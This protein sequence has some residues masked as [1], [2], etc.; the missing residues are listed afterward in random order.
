MGV[1]TANF[2]TFS[3]PS[4]LPWK[5]ESYHVSATADYRRLRKCN[6]KLIIRLC[7][8]PTHCCAWFNL[9]E[10]GFNPLE[11]AP[12]HLLALSSV[13]SYHFFSW[14]L[15]F[16]LTCSIH[17]WITCEI[18]WKDL[19]WESGILWYTGQIVFV[20][21]LNVGIPLIYVLCHLM[22][23]SHHFSHS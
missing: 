17:A 2:L 19:L 18:Q 3:N 6:L 20:F 14:V 4:F 1:C 21:L 8:R 16:Q 9:N 11:G 22:F 7:D 12:D 23:Q 10:W 15:Q 13:V 5:L